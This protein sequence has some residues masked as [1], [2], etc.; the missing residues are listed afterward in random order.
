MTGRSDAF[1]T[2]L[3]ECLEVSSRPPIDLEALASRIGV[4]Q[5]R[6]TDMAE[7]GRLVQDGRRSVVYLRRGLGRGRR[8]FT[9]AHELAHRALIDPNAPTTAYR[10]AGNNGD[11]E[12]ICDEIAA[13]LLMPYSWMQSLNTRPQN[14][15]TLRLISERAHVSLSAALVRSREVNLWKKSLLRF[16][17]DQGKWRLQGASGIP[18]EWHRSIRSGTS[19]HEVLNNIPQRRDSE[20][21][22]PLRAGDHELAT[23]AQIDRSRSSAIALIELDKQLSL[24]SRP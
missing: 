10:R 3:F 5:I 16:S 20:R 8:R 13:A 4:E 19:T 17:L 23:T 21:T 1:A 6:D 18:V 11:E 12:R 9:L 15:S 7:D 2:W 22:L 14:L 24:L